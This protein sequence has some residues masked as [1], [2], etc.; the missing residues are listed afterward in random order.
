MA[1]VMANPA[2][3]RVLRLHFTSYFPF[4][5]PTLPNLT[6]NGHARSPRGVILF[7]PAGIGISGQED[8]A[9]LAVDVPRLVFSIFV[10]YL[11]V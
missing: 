6:P 9:K 8:K 2:V 1:S 10:N 11:E 4:D 5:C 3:I 7:L